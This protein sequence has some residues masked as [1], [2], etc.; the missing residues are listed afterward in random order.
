VARIVVIGGGFGGLTTALLLARDGHHVTVLERDAEPPADPR[1]A[2]DTWTRRG[3][4]QFRL[5]HV[6]M[7]RVREIF[8]AEL[9][10]VNAALMAFGAHR[11]NRIVEL[12]VEMTGGVRPG[13]ERFDVLTGRR[14]MVEATIAATAAAEDGIDVRRGVVVRALAPGSGRPAGVPHVTAAVLATGERIPADLVVDCS[15]R[16]S[17][18]PAMLEAM[19]AT[20]P[21]DELG[22]PGFVYYCRHFHGAELPALLGPPLQHYDSLSFVTIPGDNHT[23]SVGVMSTTSDTWMRQAGDPQV[24]SRILRSY[25]LLAH[26]IDAEAT[27]DVQVMARTPD[28]ITRYLVDGRPVATGIVA[29]GDAAAST[30]PA[31]GRGL[32]FAAM[33]A[34]CLRDVLREV[35]TVDAAELSHRWHDRVGNVVHPFVED[36][37]ALARHRHAEIEAQIAG[38]RHRPSD[39]GWELGQALVRAAA[40]DPELLRAMLGVASVLERGADIARCRD[41][42]VRLQAVGNQPGLPGPSRAELEASIGNARAA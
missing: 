7:P 2:F 39:P 21:V 25:P 29:I 36:T 10:D 30:S 35:P 23:W 4:P 41:L 22:D 8:D 20:R 18:V 28:R 33:G 34:R 9:A 38:R 12:P 14:A 40:H 16:R 37:L 26:W 32:S 31:Y 27:T 5:P 15:G 3:V 6:V 17:T 24:W 19:G 11:S 42:V 13:D 1:T